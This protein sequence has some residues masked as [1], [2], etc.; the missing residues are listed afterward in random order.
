M[1]G[2][3]IREYPVTLAEVWDALSEAQRA[4]L[5]ALA[6]EAETPAERRG[7]AAVLYALRGAVRGVRISGDRAGAGGGNRTGDG[8]RGGGVC[9]AGITK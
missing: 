8:G 2:E 1:S 3:V 5:W 4:E 7:G 6:R 9:P